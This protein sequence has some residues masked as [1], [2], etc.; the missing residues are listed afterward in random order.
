MK[1]IFHFLLLSVFM[2]SCANVIKPNVTATPQATITFTSTPTLTPTTMPTPTEDPMAHAPEGTTSVSADGKTYYMDTT[3]KDVSYHYTWDEKG[4]LWLRSLT[5]GIPLE[6]WPVYDYIPLRIL[7]SASAEGEQNLVS[8]THTNFTESDIDPVT[9]RFD[10][11][12]LTST[13]DVEVEDRY[14]N[15]DLSSSVPQSDDTKFQ[16]DVRDGKA[17]LPIITSSGEN[18]EGKLS[19]TTGFV[20]T[21]VGYTDLEPMIGKGVT[22]WKDPTGAVF[23]STVIGVD[24]DGNICGEIAFQGDIRSLSEKQ[25]R[26]M[27]FSI[28]S[29]VITDEDQRVQSFNTLTDDFAIY[30]AKL[31]KD[32]TQD[33]GIVRNP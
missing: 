16:H 1:R 22:K 7:I 17:F 32:G 33:I 4:K 31:R 12:P 6:D 2:T 21:I 9:R 10:P 29:N 20:T 8:L 25:V 14:F 15:V 11:P 19:E 13:F 27:L 18:A 24:T 23:L 30:S 3:E 28:V 5:D 26:W